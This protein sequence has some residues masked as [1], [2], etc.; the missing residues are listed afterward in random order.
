[1]LINYVGAR[2]LIEGVLPAIANRGGIAI[3]SSNAG[4]AWQRN[5]AGYAELLAIADAVEAG[6]RCEKHPEAVRDG[7]TSS[8]EMLIIWAQHRAV[9]LGRERGIRI[10][11]T[12]PCPTKTAFMDETVKVMGQEFFDR[13]PYPLLGRMATPE[14]QAWPLILLNS[15]LNAAVTGAL[16]YTDQGFTGGVFTGAIDASFMMGGGQ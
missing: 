10:N 13:F 5:L 1:M 14:E 3:I 2:Q 16:V 11:C 8:K 12:A 4:L 9:S 6:R 15:K 7:Y